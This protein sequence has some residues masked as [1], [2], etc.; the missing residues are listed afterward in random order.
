MDAVNQERLIKIPH[1]SWAMIAQ[2]QTHKQ[3]EYNLNPMSRALPPAL[4]SLEY[5][6]TL[7]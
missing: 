2:Y 7:R 4:S 5:A 3:P 1:G 6:S